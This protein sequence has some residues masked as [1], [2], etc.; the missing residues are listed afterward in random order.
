[1]KKRYT[2]EKSL[3][4]QHFFA[5]SWA[6]KIF[7]MKSDTYN[8]FGAPFTSIEQPLCFLGFHGY[9]DFPEKLNNVMYF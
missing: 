9:M 5:S 2:V 8:C 3:H 7:P 1:M 6:Q 4:F